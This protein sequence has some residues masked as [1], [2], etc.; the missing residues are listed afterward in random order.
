MPTAFGV[1]EWHG[2]NVFNREGDSVF[3]TYFINNSGDEAMGTVWSYL[4][5]TAL[6]RQETWDDS[7]AGYPQTNRTSGGTGT[8]NTHPAHRRTRDG[9]KWSTTLWWVTLKLNHYYMTPEGRGIT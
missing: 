2:T 6:G 4:D 7:P 9:S 8:T 1:D 5:M 3:R